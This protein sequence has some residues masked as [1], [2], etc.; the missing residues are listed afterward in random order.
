MYSKELESLI[1]FALIDGDIS[2]KERQILLEKALSLGVNLDEFEMVLEA[3]LFEKK[4]Q[5][6]PLAAAS[7][8]DKMKIRKCTACGAI[9]ESFV[10]RCGDC[11]TDFTN[12]KSSASIIEFTQMLN[13]IEM[14]RPQTDQVN[15]SNVGCQEVAKWVL[16]WPFLIP[17]KIVQFFIYQSKS[18]QGDATDVR[19]KELILNFPVPIS[20]E[21]VFEFLTLSASKINVNSYLQSLNDIG[22]VNNLW[23][24]IW[25]KK[26]EQIALK[27]TISMGN[28]AAS[29]TIITEIVNNAKLKL[30]SNKEKM[31][32]LVIGFVVVL[33]IFLIVIKLNS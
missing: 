25:L 28:D 26:I 8:S 21:E 11:G 30:K 9:A 18:F 31:V 32:H 29:L 10:T 13:E 4:Q 20:K 2:E 23:N 3:K 24:L 16:F 14:S 17:I 33:A 5:K 7:S 1:D 19:K 12:I 22:K 15:T 6:A 27:A